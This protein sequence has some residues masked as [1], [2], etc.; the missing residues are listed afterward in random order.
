M[1]FLLKMI[2]CKDAFEKLQNEVTSELQK[3]CQNPFI[4][5]FIKIQDNKLY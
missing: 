1:M 5:I 3:I 4:T 2:N